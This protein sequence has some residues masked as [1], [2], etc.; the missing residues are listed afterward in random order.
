ML[1]L[2]AGIKKKKIHV[3]CITMEGFYEGGIQ[4]L[5]MIKIDVTF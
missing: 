5:T 1:Q 4:T 2:S 3:R